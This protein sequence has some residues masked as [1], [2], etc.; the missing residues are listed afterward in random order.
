MTND[1]RRHGGFTLVELLVVLGVVSL[2]AAILL[3]AIHY[4]REGA[5]RTTCAGNLRQIGIAMLSYASDKGAFPF[6]NN[7]RRRFSPGAMIL[8]YADRADA[9]NAL[10]FQVFSTDAENRT[11]ARIKLSLFMCPSD[12]GSRVPAASTSYAYSTGYGYQ[13]SE[14]LNG[15]FSKSSSSPVALASITDGLSTTTLMSEWI[16]GSLSRTHVEQLQNVFS[17]PLQLSKRDEFDAFVALCEKQDLTSSPNRWLTKGSE[18][19][20]GEMGA[21]A[22]NHNSTPNRNSC[23]NANLVFHGSWT[24]GSRH[25]SGVYVLFADGRVR[26]AI[27]T[28][29]TSVW[30]VMSTRAGGEPASLD[31]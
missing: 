5:R 15:V 4:A 3:P 17:T 27:D 1:H 10:N 28:V 25:A 22:Y 12:F 24:A 20:L 26:F 6:I 9:Y 19:I 7:G 29:A 30:R 16:L 2:L 14:S 13:I 21:T 23:F 8:P 18:W 11:V 31:F